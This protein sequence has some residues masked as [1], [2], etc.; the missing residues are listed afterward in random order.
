MITTD[1]NATAATLA[2]RFAGGVAVVVGGLVLVGWALEIATLK[3]VLPGWVSMKPNAAVGFLLIGLALL[4]LTLQRSPITQQPSIL[5]TRLA[6]LCALL[7][8]LAALCFGL[9][10]A[11]MW[12]VSLDASIVSAQAMGRPTR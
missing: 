6:R 10:A 3:S 1:A 9:L 5:F 8:G 11:A 2:A 4:L 7:A 12:L